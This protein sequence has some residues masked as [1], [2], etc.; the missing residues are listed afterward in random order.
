MNAEQ[1]REVLT[2]TDV[3]ISARLV[4][5][6]LN[7]AAEPQNSNSLAEELG[8]GHTTISRCVGALKKRGLIRRRSGV[9][10]PEPAK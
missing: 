9:W 10:I 1:I 4:W 7:V 3:P 8:M 2:D 6:Y 5:A